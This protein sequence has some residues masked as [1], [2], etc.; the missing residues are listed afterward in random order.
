MDPSWCVHITDTG[1][2]LHIHECLLM[3]V[4]IFPMCV[5]MS[6][7]V[8][9]LLCVGRVYLGSIFVQVSGVISKNYR[10]Y[11]GLVNTSLWSYMRGGITYRQ[12]SIYVSVC[13]RDRFSCLCVYELV[14]VVTWAKITV[15]FSKS[16]NIKWHNEISILIIW[17]YLW[18]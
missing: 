2:V 11:G 4:T 3:S 13:M 1:A 14:P 8:V 6:S 12:D 10:Y 17:G 15:K 7:H 18:C 5:A 16:W 9:L